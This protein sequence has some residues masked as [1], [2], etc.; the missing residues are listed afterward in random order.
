MRALYLR[1]LRRPQVEGDGLMER[2]VVALVH[3]GAAYDL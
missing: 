1:V 2:A 3:S